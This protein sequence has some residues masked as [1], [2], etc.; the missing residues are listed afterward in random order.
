MLVPHWLVLVPFRVH[1]SHPKC[2]RASEIL[3]PSVASNNNNDNDDSNKQ[4][5]RS[6]TTAAPCPRGK[7]P[8]F[9]VHWDKEVI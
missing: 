1:P 9:S 4:P 3:Y 6:R 5:G 2:V 8:E 7:Q